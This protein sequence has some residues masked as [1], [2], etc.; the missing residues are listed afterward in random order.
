MNRITP[1]ES[2]W[3]SL[4]LQMRAASEADLRA[5]QARVAQEA[6]EEI[7]KRRREQRRLKKR[8]KRDDS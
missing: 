4:L 3:L 5:A 7:E 2:G 1:Y 6:V 8:R